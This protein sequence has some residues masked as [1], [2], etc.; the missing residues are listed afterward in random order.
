MFT[1][2]FMRALCTKE[3]VLIDSAIVTKTTLTQTLNI[4]VGSYR[5]KRF[6]KIIDRLSD[7]TITISQSELHSDSFISCF[8]KTN[9]AIDK[10]TSNKKIDALIQV[11]LS[12]L[13][14]NLVLN[15]PDLFHEAISIFSELSN[16]EIIILEIARK[17]LPSS[18]GD[19]VVD[20]NN[21]AIEAICTQLGV[22]KD[23]AYVLMS[24]LQRT[25]FII[26]SAMLGN[27]RYFCKTALLNEVYSYVDLKINSLGRA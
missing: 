3:V 25:G 27:L 18:G 11:F 6:E 5:K 17:Y 21:M 2:Q 14:T 26:D 12:G 15:L 10:A 22:E 23:L 7:G 4:A 24:R 19:N 13:R 8:L 20:K 16:R 1:P 9:E